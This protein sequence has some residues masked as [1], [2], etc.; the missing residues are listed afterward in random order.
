M[1]DLKTEIAAAYLRSE[2][3][4]AEQLSAVIPAPD[5]LDTETI[6]Q[7]NPF[8]EFCAASGVHHAPA[9]PATVAAYILHQASQGI[10]ADRIVAEVSA[11]EQLHNY[12]GFANPVA[13]ASA[14][15]A[16]GQILQ[17][18]PPRSWTRLEKGMFNNLPPEIRAAIARR[19]ADQ[20]K[21]M[22]RAQN[23]AAELRHKLKQAADH[24]Q[25]VIEEEE[26]IMGKKPGEGPYH[27]NDG[28]PIARREPDPGNSSSSKGKDISRKVDGNNTND[29]FSGPLKSE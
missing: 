13:T 15:F 8:V 9:T 25:P 28:D 2:Q 16:I 4:L 24:K 19:A 14:R 1:V 26:T 21:S 3:A 27:N 17:T 22:R 29:G 20:E 6:A 11:I 23:E 5:E 12:Y 7:L 10:P 18:E